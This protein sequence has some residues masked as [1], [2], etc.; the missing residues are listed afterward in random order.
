MP[1][2]NT[3]LELK[4]AELQARDPQAE[5]DIAKIRAN[6]DKLRKQVFEKMPVRKCKVREGE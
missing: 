4:L 3:E 1:A 2:L 5:V 6:I